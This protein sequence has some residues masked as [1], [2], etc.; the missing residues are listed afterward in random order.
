MERYTLQ[1]P[2]TVMPDGFAP[3]SVSLKSCVNPTAELTPGGVCT[4]LLEVTADYMEPIPGARDK[5]ITVL[6][7][8]LTAWCASRLQQEAEAMIRQIQS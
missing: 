3:V 2:D 1:F 8:M 7:I 5:L 6:K 4:A